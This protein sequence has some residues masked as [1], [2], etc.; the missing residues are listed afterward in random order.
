MQRLQ[1]FCVLIFNAPGGYVSH[2]LFFDV[3]T[4]Q[5]AADKIESHFLTPECQVLIAPIQ[6]FEKF[7]LSNKLVPVKA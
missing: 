2:T 5:E 3:E 7:T 6:V 1:R 4:T